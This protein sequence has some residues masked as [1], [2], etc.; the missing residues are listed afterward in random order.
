[1]RMKIL[2]QIQT[3]EAT[4]RDNTSSLNSVMQALEFTSNQ[5][6]ELLSKVNAL[7]NKVETLQKEN[8]TLHDKC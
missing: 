4:V 1:M 6:E 2:N 7:Q 3:L 8:C 5:V